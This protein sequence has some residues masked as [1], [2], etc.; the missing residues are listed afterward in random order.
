MSVIANRYARAFSDVVFSA[1]LDANATIAQLDQFVEMTSSNPALD[2]VFISPSVPHDQKIKLLDTLIARTGAF[3]Q[4]RNFLAVLIDHRRIH[5]LPEIARQF[6]T[7]L[8]DRLGFAEAEVTTARELSADQ[9]REME[10]HI[11]RLTGRSVQT[12]Y[13]LD[14]QLLG[15]AIVK[16]GSTIYDGSVSGQLEQV[17]AQLAAG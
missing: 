15:G 2:E 16:V 13:S 12:R 5:E 9:K 7:E 14:P 8:N 17:K 10:A 3:R 1:K 6:K 11:A 4:T